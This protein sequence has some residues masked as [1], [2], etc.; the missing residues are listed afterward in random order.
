MPTSDLIK[1]QRTIVNL[2]HHINKEYPQAVG[3]LKLLRNSPDSK[4]R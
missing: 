2:H 4:Q 1:Q 3:T